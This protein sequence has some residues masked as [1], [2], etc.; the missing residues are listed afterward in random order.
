MV[1]RLGFDAPDAVE[2]PVGGAHF[3]DHPE[4]DA[5]GRLE[6]ALVILDEDIEVLG[7]FAGEN[8]TLGEQAVLNSVLRRTLFSVGGG[9]SMGLGAVGAGGVLSSIGGHY[10]TRVGVGEWV[11]GMS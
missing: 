8:Q 6:T 3:L 7:T 11:I 2:A 9:G 1:E 10:N 4:F 5:V